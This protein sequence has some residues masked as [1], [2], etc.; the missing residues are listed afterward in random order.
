MP[1]KTIP[2]K[3]IE[4]FVAEVDRKKIIDSDRVETLKHIL[5]APGKIKKADLIEAIK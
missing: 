5:M 4:D 1:R 3:I 2:E